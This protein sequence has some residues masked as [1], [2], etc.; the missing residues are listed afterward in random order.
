M[1]STPLSAPDLGPLSP[2][3][4]ELA[5]AFVTLAS[6]IA[7]VMDEQGVIRTVA[8]GRHSGDEALLP[9]A[10]AWVGRRWADTVS[11][12]TRGKVDQLLTEVTRTGLARRREISHPLEEGN[13]VAVAYTAV[14]LGV[15]GPVLAVGRDLRAIGA[16]QQRFLEAQR[17]MERGY[18]QVR[19]N[20]A[21]HRLLFQVATDA[22]VL[23]DATQH[24]IQEANPAA[25]ALFGHPP[26]QLIG[27]ALPGFFLQAHRQALD[28]LTATVLQ[29]AQ[30]AEIRTRLLNHSTPASVALTPLP[31]DGGT[32]V[33][34]RVRLAELP[35]GD[36]A[37]DQTLSRLVDGA[38]DPVLVSDTAGHVLLA[39]PAFLRL[40]RLGSE[41]ELKGRS[42]A[43]WLTWPEGDLRELLQRVRRGGLSPALT[44]QL[45]GGD[46]P[47]MPVTFSAALLAEDDFECIGWS[48]RR[49]DNAGPAIAGAEALQ[50]ALGTLAARIGQTPLPELMREAAAL[51][52]RHFIGLALER[53][54]EDTAAAARMLGISEQRV[55]G[56]PRGEPPHPETS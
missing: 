53:T 16:I 30:P 21:R 42:I 27:H 41:R 19:Q 26:E 29:S 51:L 49:A 20:E 33:L 17:E 36:N 55:G 54:H 35:S 46:A 48:L 22:V 50:T 39:N 28:D 34:V 40:A 18:W 12:D 4:P 31:A 13:S 56:R 1:N 25:A 24:R 45:L 5:Q 47:A 38:S 8:Q 10:H 14:R 43:D 44:G 52:E 23:V 7:L 32:R 2:W 9:S 3:A 37:L 15:A 11:A 6:D